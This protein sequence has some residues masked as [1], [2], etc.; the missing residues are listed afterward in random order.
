M[1]EA[2]AHAR[3]VDVGMSHEDLLDL[4][5]VHVRPTAEDEVLAA[6]GE[7]D[8][9]VRVDAAHVAEGESGRVEVGQRWHG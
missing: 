7:V 3:L 2:R 1:G 5:G 8:V 6:V 4:G 9:A